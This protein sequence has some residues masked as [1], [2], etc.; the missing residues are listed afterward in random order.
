MSKPGV[1]LT[2]PDEAARRKLAKT[3]VS[4]IELVIVISIVMLLLLCGAQVVSGLHSLVARAEVA[5][6]SATIHAEQQKATITGE[7][8]TITFSADHAGYATQARTH[9]FQRGVA[10]AAPPGCTRPAK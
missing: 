5:L 10:F 9:Q 8:R 4:I 3:G 1:S 7:P 6:L 2:K